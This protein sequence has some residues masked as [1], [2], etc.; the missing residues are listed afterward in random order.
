MLSLVYMAGGTIPDRGNYSMRLAH[1]HA[2][3]G[4]LDEEFVWERRVGE[5][6]SLGT[7]TWRIQN[8]S[9]NHIDV[10]PAA[11]EPGTIPFWRAEARSRDFHTS[12]HIG[13]FLEFADPLIDHDD[14]RLR[15]FL[16]SRFFM[17]PTAAQQLISF[18]ALQKSVT[19]TPLPHRHHLVIEHF[20]DAL[21]RKDSKQVVI[22]TFWGGRINRPYAMALSAAMEAAYHYPMEFFADDDAVLLLLPHAFDTDMLF[23]LVTPDTIETLLRKKLEKTGYFG[24]M[25]RENA[26]RA[27]LLPRQGFKKRMPLWLNRLRAKKLLNAVMDT[28]EFPILIETFRS[29]MRD[30]FDLD[31]LKTLL[32][33][34]TTGEIKVSHT[35]TFQA[36]PFC[37][38]LLFQQ[39]N[40]YMYEDDTPD[41]GKTSD[42]SPA[43]LKDIM[44]DANVFGAISPSLSRRLTR[45]LQRTLPGYAPASPEDLLDWVRERT[46]L[47]EDEWKILLQAIFNDHGLDE[48]AILKTIDYKLVRISPPGSAVKSVAAVEHLPRIETALAMSPGSLMLHPV[49]SRKKRITPKTKHAMDIIRQ[50]KPND[51]E[52]N[53]DDTNG[54]SPLVSQ[55]LAYYGP[56]PVDRLTQVWGVSPTVMETVVQT[57]IHME[58]I[59][60]ATFFKNKEDMVCDRDN[61]EILL[62]MARYERRSPAWDN[63]Q[64]PLWLRLSL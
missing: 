26:G 4:E 6:F 64:V 8:I 43:L 18:L 7:Q 47:P 51:P 42:L 11:E 3:L 29:C 53:E 40:K 63:R 46:L 12:E 48:Q 57:L 37:G 1:T 55:W 19:A 36:S 35:T 56:L 13:N 30:D 39:T 60:R 28:D 31:T 58:Q 22:H 50:K 52:E 5:T 10:V 32:T 16:L 23:T 44:E 14:H 27:L 34:L 24:A 45:K 59:I 17:E 21:N 25:F 41:S 54:I 62:R 61:L 49:D 15:D 38:N 9:P 20:D 33:E 2:A